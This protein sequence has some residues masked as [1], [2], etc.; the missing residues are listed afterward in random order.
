MLSSK[1]EDFDKGGVWRPCIL[2]AK[3]YRTIPFAK[4][5]GCSPHHGFHK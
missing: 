1:Q 3:E 5:Y 2:A 4:T